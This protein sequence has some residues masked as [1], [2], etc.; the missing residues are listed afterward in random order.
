MAT[1][2]VEGPGFINGMLGAFHAL[3][4]VRVLAIFFSLLFVWQVL[5]A[6]FI[7]P[8]RN[9][10]GSLLARLSAKHS[11]LKRVLANGSESVKAD[12]QTYG[13]VYVHRPNGVSISDPKDIRAVLLSQEFRKTEIYKTL[14]ILGN[15]SIF[16]TRD[17]I[18]ASRRRRQIGPYLNHGFLARMEPLILRYSILAIKTKWDNLIEKNG[19]KPV[20][21]NYRDDTQYATFDTIGALAFGREFKALENDDPTIIRWIEATGFYLGMTKN[22]PLLNYYPFSHLIRRSRKMFDDFINYSK[23]SV[24]I[25]RDSLTKGSSDKPADLLQAFID[26]EDPESKIKMAPHEVRTESIAMQ[27]AG[28]ESTSFV[29]SWVIHLLT[30]YPEYL[31]RAIRE[32]RDQ[33]PVSHMVTFAECRDQL[34]FLE[35][36]IYETLR[37]SPITSGFMPRVSHSKGITLQGGHYIPP[38][39]E[40]AINLIGVHNNPQVWKDPH[41]YNP[42]RFLDNEESKRDV[43]AFSYGH[44]NCIGRNLA[45]FE[46][47]VI[48]ANILKDY[49]IA[50]PEDSVCGPHNVDEFG[51]PRLMP[52][53]STLFTTPKHPERDCRLVVAKRK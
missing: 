51:Q 38:N 40:V 30:L 47:M 3:G 8:L 42:I 17:P 39:Y 12:Y 15:P 7:S 31:N 28:S 32:V 20:T 45:W 53:R 52:T 50:L 41:L 36:C 23:E 16:T 25:R 44:R 33:F 22:F 11:I 1:M 13:D 18:Q 21:I 6:L 49:D 43:F 46:I 24:E 4:A 34:P 48:I 29:T 5:Y 27:L 19:G 9:I 14:D 10:P 2:E 37:Y 26:A 35:A